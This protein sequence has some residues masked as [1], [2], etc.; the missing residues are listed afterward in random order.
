MSH[1]VMS[2]AVFW[3]AIV[4]DGR[5]VRPVLE[6]E[7]EFCFVDL[8]IGGGLGLP[9]NLSADG[10]VTA[11][12]SSEVGSDELAAGAAKVIDA[13]GDILPDVNL[14]VRISDLVD[15]LHGWQAEVAWIA[16]VPQVSST[17]LK[18]AASLSEPSFSSSKRTTPEWAMR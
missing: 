14:A 9:K 15:D 16:A 2:Y 12:L 13:V 17:C 10:E 5:I 4:A 11:L 6:N 1:S 8:G 3:P 18:M 7:P